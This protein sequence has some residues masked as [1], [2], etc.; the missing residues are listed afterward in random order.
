MIENLSA[1]ELWNTDASMSVN[2]PEKKSKLKNTIT[3]I[4]QKVVFKNEALNALIWLRVNNFSLTWQENKV[5][6]SKKKKPDV[7]Y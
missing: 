5:N 3:L 4:Y 2:N 6:F 7:I 1:D